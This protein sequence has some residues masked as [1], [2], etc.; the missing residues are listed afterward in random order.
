LQDGLQDDLQEKRPKHAGRVRRHFAWGALVATLGALLGA[1]GATAPEGGIRPLSFLPEGH[2]IAVGLR[3]RA[4]ATA[5]A[6]ARAAADEARWQE[7]EVALDRAEAAELLADQVTL[8]RARIVLG[9]G[10]PPAA[11]AILDLL[12]RTRP[13]AIVQAQIDR[14]RAPA[15]LAAGDEAGARAAWHRAFEAESESERRADVKLE[16]VIAL[17]QAGL[18][19]A[20]ALPETLTTEVL[21]E[22]SRPD[23]KAPDDRT[24]DEAALAGDALLARGRSAAAALAY[25]E[26]LSGLVEE[27]ARRAVHQRHGVALFKLRRYGEARGAF[28]SA[29]EGAEAR[30]WT[31]R[32]AAR[33]GDVP[34]AMRVFAHLGENGDEEPEWASRS[35]Y[36][37]GTLQ[38]GRGDES[39]ARESFSRVLGFTA[40]PSRVREALWRIGWAEFE[41]GQF[42][43]AR[44]HFLAMVASAVAEGLE[45]ESTWRPRYWAAR[46]AAEAGHEP[47]ARSGFAELVAQAPLS[48]YGLRAQERLD[49]HHLAARSGAAAIADATARRRVD[50][51][52][53]Q[54]AAL[55]V[56]A[57]MAEQARLELRALADRPLGLADRMAIGRVMVAAEDFAGAQ[58]IVVHAYRAPLVEGV[59]PGVE[60]LWWLAWP[61]A[62]REAVALAPPLGVSSELVWAI[63]REESSFRPRVHSTAGAIGLMQL[64][65]DTASRVARRSDLEIPEPADLERPEVNVALGTR[66][67]AE[68]DKRMQGRESAMIASYNAGPLAVARWLRDAPA[69]QPDDVF[70]EDIPYTQT[71]S[72]AKRVLRSYWLYQRLYE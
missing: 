66:Y 45:P 10:D 28:E 65:P 69:G 60:R 43:G 67:L 3:S 21:R 54:R 41:D 30:Y 61:R 24:P 56:E 12:E 13:D 36:L 57:G 15:L 7:A 53:L 44:E 8:V 46:A 18:M 6:A 71:R 58:R 2:G 31:G 51:W 52:R 34:H 11:L 4:G 68:L 16:M 23:E 38:S 27:S 20:D 17:Q 22:A 70:V 59:R 26:A 29:G 64:M 55:L 48:Y 39:A 9:Q 47:E 50:Y 42:D 72:Y 25:A 5:L 40:F 32:A 49:Q 33:Q 35:L 63:M 19:P 14:L 1:G 37:L 62:Y